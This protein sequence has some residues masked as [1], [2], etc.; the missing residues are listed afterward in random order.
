MFAKIEPIIDY[1]VRGLCK[2]A[3][4]NHPKGCPNWGKDKCPPIIA[5]LEDFF[6]IS[7][8]MYFIWNE[9]DLGSHIERMKEKHPDWSDY[10][11]R[12]VLYW[13]PKARKQLKEE[14][15]KFKKSHP[16][17]TI[18]TGPEAMGINVTKTM[19]QLGIKLDWPPTK[20]SYQVAIAGIKKDKIK[21]NLEI[22]FDKF[23]NFYSIS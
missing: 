2:K 12:C 19:E 1:S 20:S 9:F 5:K 21:E 10:Q 16:E 4:H 8:P 11:L 22:N 14:I 13:Q 18:S 3:Y 23:I 17:Y 7:Q 6:D 15:I